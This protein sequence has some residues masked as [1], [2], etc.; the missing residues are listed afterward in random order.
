MSVRCQNQVE[1]RLCHSLNF[2]VFAT[3]TR[4]QI[5]FVPEY[6]PKW[7]WNVRKSTS[8]L[9]QLKITFLFG[10]LF[11]SFSLS[12]SLHLLF[13]HSIYMVHLS[14]LQFRSRH[15][16]YSALPLKID[17][18]SA[19]ARHYCVQSCLQHCVRFCTASTLSS[20]AIEF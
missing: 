10:R 20:A 7:C 3:S 13:S 2:I 4:A 8:V 6:L 1:R 15:I 18:T 9:F 17:Y 12:L 11:Y 16:F 19:L 5:R 14:Q